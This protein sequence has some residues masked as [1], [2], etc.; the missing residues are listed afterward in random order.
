M[1]K[2]QINGGLVSG[3][4]T[5]RLTIPKIANGYSD[6]QLDDYGG[7]RRRDY[8]HRA[9][10]TLSLR[11][12]FSHSQSE[13]VG[14]AGFGF[15]NAPFGDVTVKTPVLPQATWFFFASQPNNLPFTQGKTGWFAATID[16]K[17]WQ[18]LALIPFAPLVTILNQFKPLRDTIWPRAE[19]QLGIYARPIAAPMT[20]WHAYRIEWLA[21]RCNFFVDEQPVLQAPVSPSGPL[22]FVCWIDNQFLVATPTARFRAGAIATPFEQSL[23]IADL[24]ID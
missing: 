15:W 17:R 22:G 6:A 5:N 2:L 14:T 23:E 1:R 21:D 10:C 9:P 13:L 18:A 20:D 3:E 4:Q 7:L 19:R 16:A 11:A 12:R 24:V 8:P